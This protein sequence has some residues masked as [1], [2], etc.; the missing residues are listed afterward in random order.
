VAVRTR[1]THVV[2]LL[3]TVIALLIAMWILATMNRFAFPGAVGARLFHLLTDLAFLFCVLAGVVL[4]AD[5]ISGEKREGTIGFLFLAPL[6]AYD[7]VAGKLIGT[8]LNAAYALIAILPVLAIPLLLGGVTGGELAR[9]AVVLLNTLFLSLS[10]GLLVSSCSRHSQRAMLCTG[11]LV[12]GGTYILPTLPHLN[13]LSPRML[14][15]A[16]LDAVFAPAPS[17]FFEALALQHFLGWGLLILASF[18]TARTWRASPLSDV[19][20]ES[21]RRRTPWPF[22]RRTESISPLGDGNATEWLARRGRQS[23]WI[24]ISLALVS[25]VWLAAQAGARVPMPRNVIVMAASL[26]ITI[27]FWVAWEAARRLNESRKSGALELLLSTPLKPA[28]VVR[29]QWLSLREQFSG[30]IITVLAGDLALLLATVQGT[31]WQGE[32]LAEFLTIMAAMIF[33]FIVNS[34][35]LGWTGL[36]LGLRSPNT[37]QA[38]LGALLRIIVLPTAIFMAVIYLLWTSKI[39]GTEGPEAATATWVIVSGLVSYLFFEQ[40]RRWLLSDTCRQLACQS[41]VPGLQIALPVEEVA[42][43]VNDNYALVR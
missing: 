4:T 18:F 33:L 34:I 24:W 35:S 19:R 20:D 22:K 27:E 31:P 13:S 42:P 6:R 43:E 2:R 7:I 30:P 1:T 36:W 41:T 32:A 16:A 21:S 23:V 39:A 10:A 25:V 37:S 5:C 40:S 26:H 11:A 28:Q 12:L 38:T 17:R 8:S 14:N 15:R 29:A 3:G 9:T